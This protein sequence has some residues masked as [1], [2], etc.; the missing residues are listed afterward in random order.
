[1]WNRIA[2]IWYTSAKPQYWPARPLS[3]WRI[4]PNWCAEPTRSKQKLTDRRDLR[5][6]RCRRRH[7]R[8]SKLRDIII[9]IL[10]CTTKRSVRFYLIVV[11]EVLVNAHS[12][13]AEQAGWRTADSCGCGEQGILES[14][15]HRLMR[16][17]VI[18]NDFCS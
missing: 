12:N 7:Y 15:V 9:I 18:N 10:F 5:F 8:R 2:R 17:M 3:T 16:V 4:W 13:L 1:M 14:T 11:A 6:H